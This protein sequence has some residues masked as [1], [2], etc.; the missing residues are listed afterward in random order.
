MAR[1]SWRRAS[2]PTD[3]KN[4]A[5]YK[6]LL[7]SKKR[8]KKW[9]IPKGRAEPHMSEQFLHGTLFEVAFFGDELLK[10]F[11]VGIRIAQ[12]LGYGFLFGFGGRKRDLQITNVIDLGVPYC[13]TTDFL[14]KIILNA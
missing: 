8:S 5:N 11:D 1:C 6:Y 10:G 9:G 13:R 14:E 7:V 2:W 4:T 12:R 3:V